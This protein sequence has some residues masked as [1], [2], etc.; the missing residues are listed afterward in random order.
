MSSQENSSN[1]PVSDFP[2]GATEGL[3]LS[4]A[5]SNGNNP[6]PGAIEA[7]FWFLTLLRLF[8]RV[9]KKGNPMAGGQARMTLI[10]RI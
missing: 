1:A 7:L 8:N 10:W 3:A 9:E 5:L 6:K 4:E 2:Y